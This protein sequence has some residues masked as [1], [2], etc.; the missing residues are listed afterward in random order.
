MVYMSTLICELEFILR[1]CPPK[2][3]EDS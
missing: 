1:I 3:K 2:M